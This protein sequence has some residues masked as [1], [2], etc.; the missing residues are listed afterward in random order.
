MTS[1]PRAPASDPRHSLPFI[2][3]FFPDFLSLFY[4]IRTI[5]GVPERSFWSSGANTTMS[6]DS[7]GWF[8]RDKANTSR[9]SLPNRLQR[10]RPQRLGA[11]TEALPLACFC[12]VTPTRNFACVMYQPRRRVCRRTNQVVGRKLSLSRG[13]GVLVRRNLLV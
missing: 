9:T 3:A 1:V 10:I 13:R 12:C 11:R 5:V 8:K 7:L 2:D 4:S 6:A